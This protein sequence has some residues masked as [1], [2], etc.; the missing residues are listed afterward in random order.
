MAQVMYKLM[1][2]L[3]Q[4]ILLQSTFYYILIAY[5]DSNNPF[6]CIILIFKE[7]WICNLVSLNVSLIKQ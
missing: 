6:T 1:K 5:A 2:V 3:M 7:F 4:E